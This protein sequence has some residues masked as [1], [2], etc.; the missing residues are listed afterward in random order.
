MGEEQKRPP[1]LL[2]QLRSSIVPTPADDPALKLLASLRDGIVSTRND[3]P[4]TDTTDFA[5]GEEIYVEE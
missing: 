1:D 5:L 2:S 3:P 4:P